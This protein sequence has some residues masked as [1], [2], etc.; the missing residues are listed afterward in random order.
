M[1]E[2]E[3]ASIREVIPA[4]VIG[5]TVIDITQHDQAFFDETGKVFVQFM[6][7][8]GDTI[9]FYIGDDGIEVNTDSDEEDEDE[10]AV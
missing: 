6:F 7:S 3:Y 8:S 10:E 1:D 9:R 2:E 4:A 5:S